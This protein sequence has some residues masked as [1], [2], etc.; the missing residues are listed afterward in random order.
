MDM[1]GSAGT[2]R[3]ACPTP[4]CH[5]QRAA[6][7]AGGSIHILMQPSGE[8]RQEPSMPYKRPAVCVLK[9]DRRYARP[10]HWCSAR[11]HGRGDRPSQA[12]RLGTTMSE[13]NGDAIAPLSG[14]QPGRVL[15]RLAH[16]RAASAAVRQTWKSAATACERGQLRT[17]SPGPLPS[18]LPMR[19]TRAPAPCAPSTGAE[20]IASNE[21]PVSPCP[22]LRGRPRRYSDSPAWA[23]RA[24]QDRR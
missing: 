9:G 11:P 19:R 18:C 3:A 17:A 23:A 15:F 12:R 24:R 8:S 5:L 6:R 20:S 1:S 21:R 2:V 14:I 16:E 7:K 13:E 22:G 10:T 4:P